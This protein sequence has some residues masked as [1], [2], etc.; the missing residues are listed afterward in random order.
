MARRR[1]KGSNANPNATTIR[2]HGVQAWLLAALI[3]VGTVAATAVA[4]RA[5]RLNWEERPRRVRL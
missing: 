5:V 1:L 2:Q 3:V 4:V